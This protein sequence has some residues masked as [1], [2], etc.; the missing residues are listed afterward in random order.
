SKSSSLPASAPSRRDAGDR[1]VFFIRSIGVHHEQ[2]AEVPSMG[3]PLH[4]VRIR[5][6]RPLIAAFRGPEALRAGPARRE[7]RPA[8]ALVAAGSNL[9]SRPA[10]HPGA[11]PGR[12][13]EHHACHRRDPV[14]P[15]AQLLLF[16][17]PPPAPAGE[18]ALAPGRSRVLD[19]T[20]SRRLREPV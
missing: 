20:L 5:P 8:G 1:S 9:V 4:A 6:R 17:L 19:R 2:L 13:V 12:A 18:A 16:H 11:G 15:R 3:L 14:G 10:P 7:S